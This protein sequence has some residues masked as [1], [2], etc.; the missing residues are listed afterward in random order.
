M[1]FEENLHKKIRRSLGGKRKTTKLVGQK[2]NIIEKG[3]SFMF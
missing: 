3:K 1:Q 2:N